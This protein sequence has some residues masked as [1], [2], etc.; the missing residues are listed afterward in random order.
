[1]DVG[2]VLGTHSELELSESLDERHAF[3]VAD[4]ATKLGEVKQSTE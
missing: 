4:G 2:E 3:D 1:M